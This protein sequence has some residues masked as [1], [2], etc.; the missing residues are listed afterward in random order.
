MYISHILYWTC[1][2]VQ[3][4]TYRLED[5]ISLC[6]R[7]A[8]CLAINYE[9]GLCVLLNTS[10]S[11]QPGQTRRGILCSVMLLFLRLVD[12]PTLFPNFVDKVCMLATLLIIL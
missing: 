10:A 11:L 3:G 1:V 2:M 8:A 9:T 7:E 12:F 4:E 6:M 5:C